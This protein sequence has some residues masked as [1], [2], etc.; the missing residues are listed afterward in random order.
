MLRVPSLNP[1]RFRG[2]AWAVD[3][4]EVRPKPSSIQLC[5]TT[6]MPIRARF[7]TAWNATS[8]SSEQA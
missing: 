4:V 6:P 8:G 3:V 1:S 5:S 7:R 2:V